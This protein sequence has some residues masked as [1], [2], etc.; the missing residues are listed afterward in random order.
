MGEG[1]ETVALVKKAFGYDLIFS[2]SLLLAL[3][4]S[5]FF[6]PTLDVID[7]KVIFCLFNLN[8][9]LLALEELH[10][11]DKVSI[12]IL[13]IQHN[14][15]RLSVFLV[16]LTFISSMLI[17]NDV[18]LITFVPLTLMIA[19]K[20]GFDP[21]YTIILQA[22]GANIGSSLT[23]LGNPQNLFLFSYYHIP[24]AQFLSLMLPFVLMGA[25]WLVILNHNT[26]NGDLEFSL[27]P[28]KTGSSI[29]ITIYMILFSAVILSVLRVID[30]RLVTILV[31]LVLLRL[32]HKLFARLDYCLLGTFICFF[33]AVANFSHFTLLSRL[34]QDSFA[35][36][37]GSFVGSVLLSQIISNVPSA[38][39]I[40][41]YSEQW[42]A[43]LLGV[44]IGGM[45]TLI[46][47]MA[48]VI[49]YRY[50]VCEY[51]QRG[52]FWQFFRYNLLSLTVFL[53]MAFYWI[54]EL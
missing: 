31:I 37:T 45:G 5:I 28:V 12:K 40:A 48:S 51:N 46:A 14:Q 6:K 42:K 44:N 13:S 25:L 1:Y 10:V 43:V 18:A 3:G 21:G 8:A 24:L 7:W 4:T 34:L 2:V 22:L 49:A 53:L 26:G 41:N 36:T 23:P 17:T 54:N 47:S 16:G 15:R 38:I 29:K 35:T 11:L 19:R 9:I 33:I 27:V 20:A 30:Y 39:L 52:Y 50:Y 32:D